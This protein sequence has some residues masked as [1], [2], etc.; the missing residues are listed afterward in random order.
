[1]RESDSE[2]NEC[3]IDGS[4]YEE[5]YSRKWYKR[6]YIDTPEPQW[7]K[8][9]KEYYIGLGIAYTGIKPDYRILD[10]GAGV[11]QVM[12]SWERMG[13]INVCGIEISHSA[14]KVRPRNMVNGTV[15]V[16]PFKDQSFDVV[17]SFALLEH[18]DESILDEVI[19]EFF[20]VGKIQFHTIAKDKGTDPSH[21]NIKTMPEWMERFAIKIRRKKY[22]VASLPDPVMEENPILIMVPED[23]LTTPIWMAYKKGESFENKYNQ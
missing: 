21:I 2:K 3:F 4:W 19:D 6:N 7:S 9:M 8:H 11:G 23:M 1:M 18:I 22:L 16:L 14:A 10:L 15:R 12:N 20:R 17:S 5:E 13:F